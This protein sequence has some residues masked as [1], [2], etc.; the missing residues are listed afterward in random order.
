MFGLTVVCAAVWWF[1]GRIGLP[2]TVTLGAGLGG[3]ICFVIGVRT[4]IRAGIEG[5]INLG[6]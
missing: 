1:G 4:A 3:F 5:V 2:G 6:R